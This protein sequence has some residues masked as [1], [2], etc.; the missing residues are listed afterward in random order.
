MGSKCAIIV[1]DMCYQS[2][3]CKHH[4]SINGSDYGLLGGA[5]IYNLYESNNLPVPDHFRGYKKEANNIAKR[6][7]IHELINNNNIEELEATDLSC[8]SID[9]LFEDACKSGT[10]GVLR[11]LFKKGPNLKIKSKCFTE[12]LE[13]N[14]DTVAEIYKQTNSE[15]VLNDLCSGRAPHFELASYLINDWEISLEGFKL[16]YAINLGDRAV[17]NRVLDREKA[18]GNVYER[19]E[20]RLA[21]EK[22]DYETLTFLFENNMIEDK[23]YHLKVI[24]RELQVKKG[25]K[26]YDYIA[27]RT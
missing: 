4:V 17:L 26:M 21:M 1:G 8:V 16:L 18:K 5:E 24:L 22:E 11:V 6:K 19:E 13:E 12:C 3:P 14:L 2:Y 20:M 25:S 9:R 10:S 15:C 7:H 27:S 23:K